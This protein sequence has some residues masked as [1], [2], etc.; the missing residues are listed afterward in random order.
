MQ[1]MSAWSPLI[2]LGCWAA[3]LST[4]LTNLLSVPRLLQALGLD[5]IYP[6]L[7]FFSKGYGKHNEPYRGYV[8]TLA[9]SVFF[10]LIAN[11]NLIAP[12]IST[13]YLVSYA[14][15]NYCTFHAA[16]V[17][18]LGW[19]PTFRFYNEWLSLF[20][21]VV[22][23]GIM[24]LIDWASAI[25]T[26]AFLFALYLV[27]VYRK[28]DVNWG[29]STQ[30]Q[31]YKTALASALQLQDVSDHVKNYSPQIL[32]LAGKPYHRPPLI[33]LAHLITKNNSLLIVGDVIPDVISYRRRKAF[34]KEADAWIAAHK[35]K[36][37]YNIVSGVDYEAGCKALVQASGFGKLTPNVVLLGFK[38][39]WRTC[40]ATE[41]MQYFNILQ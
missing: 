32:V 31:T 14:F 39:D 41:L 15:I 22:C 12:L 29:S 19:R 6:G 23:I 1:L 16:T 36:A 20:G 35:I 38:S 10:V 34:M 30:A 40:G 26:I 24:F 11:L 25:I 4:A 5:E 17:K 33:D 28:P 7:I 9:V 3:T 27:V 13:F 18:P 21:A 37:F 8:L 2:Y